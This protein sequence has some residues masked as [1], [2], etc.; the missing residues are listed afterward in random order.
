[1]SDFVSENGQSVHSRTLCF[2]IKIL[3][4]KQII[5]WHVFCHSEYI[6]IKY[7]IKLVTYKMILQ[8]Y[9]QRL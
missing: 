4:F 2:F 1:M 5:I 7:N 8:S 6:H 9:I 3:I